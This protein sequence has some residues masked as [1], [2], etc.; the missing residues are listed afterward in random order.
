M[1]ITFNST[2][3]VIHS[4]RQGDTLIKLHAETSGA[5]V[6]LT[7]RNGVSAQDAQAELEAVHSKID[8]LLVSADAMQFKGVASADSD[9]P[10]SYEP[11]WTWKAGAAGTFK[12]H[13][14]EVGD[15]LI[16][17]VSRAGS[18]NQDSDFAVV[19]SNI[20]GAVTGPASAVDGNLA[21]FD[22]AT[23]RVVRDSGLSA[24]ALNAELGMV[25]VKTV[26]ALPE[27]MPQDLKDGGLLM[28]DATVG[29]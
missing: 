18:G 5:Q 6:K 19:Q 15:M 25:W 16:A 4:R 1:A 13:V 11:G 10:A 2:Q 28:L 12:G 29:G 23:G 27:T 24:A 22:Q 7:P 14:C 3:N 17:T 9:L 21:A 20:D 26:A 8:G